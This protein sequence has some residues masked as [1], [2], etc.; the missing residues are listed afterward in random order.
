MSTAEA[1]SRFQMWALT[2]EQIVREL[3]NVDLKLR[4]AKR[5]IRELRRKAPQGYHGRLTG[6]EE[7]INEIIMNPLKSVIHTA[8]DHCEN[9]DVD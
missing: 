1:R 9:D 3:V 6:I 8:Q 5:A 7:S 4:T 2:A